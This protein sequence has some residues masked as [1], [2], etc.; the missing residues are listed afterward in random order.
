MSAS[1][2]RNH[3]RHSARAAADLGWSP[4]IHAVRHAQASWLLAGGAGLQVVEERLGHRRT[5]AVSVSHTIG[6]RG[7]HGRPPGTWSA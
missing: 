1:W 2:F 7:E 4:R 6:V 3:C 5:W